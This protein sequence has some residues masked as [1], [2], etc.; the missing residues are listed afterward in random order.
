[1]I[2]KL[3]FLVLNMLKQDF[4]LQQY[5]NEIKTLSFIQSHSAPVIL[6]IFDLNGENL[7]G[8][9]Q[10]LK[11]A[12]KKYPLCSIEQSIETENLNLAHAW[13]KLLYNNI[14][15]ICDLSLDLN[16]IMR[17]TDTAESNRNKTDVCIIYLAYWFTYFC[18][19]FSS[20]L[21]FVP[22]LHLLSAMFYLS[23]TLSLCL[24]AVQLSF[25]FFPLNM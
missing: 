18:Y 22:T 16:V 10:D 20:L 17:I 24:S 11:G 19:I 6:S 12:E 7:A 13:C 9:V 4:L 2:L 1:M 8:P 3:D 5:S 25:P 23:Q 15:V 21:I 14:Q